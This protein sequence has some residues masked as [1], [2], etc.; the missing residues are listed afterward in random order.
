MLKEGRTV[1]QY[2]WVFNLTSFLANIVAELIWDSIN[3][4]LNNINVITAKQ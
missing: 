2:L 1:S 3:K 4:E